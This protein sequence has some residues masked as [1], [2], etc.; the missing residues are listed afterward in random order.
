MEQGG[1]KQTHIY[2]VILIF[3]KDPKEE[4]KYFKKWGQNHGVSMG[5]T[6]YYS[7]LTP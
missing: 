4:R 6:N 2:T 3:D 1:K 7:Y 5:N